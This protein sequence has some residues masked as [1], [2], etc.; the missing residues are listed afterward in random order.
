MNFNIINNIVLSAKDKTD[1]TEFHEL[2]FEGKKDKDKL[3]YLCT[4][5]LL[6]YLPITGIYNIA[7]DEDNIKRDIDILNAITNYIF[8]LVEFSLKINYIRS[9]KDKKIKFDEIEINEMEIIQSFDYMTLGNILYN[10]EQ[11]ETK[12]IL[13]KSKADLKYNDYKNIF[14]TLDI[15]LTRFIMDQ[16]KEE[17]KEILVK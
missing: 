11:P 12:K 17:F 10:I 5:K 8:N 15:A 13:N 3:E 7:V 16:T 1:F 9:L 14:S 4:N 2:Y 6:M